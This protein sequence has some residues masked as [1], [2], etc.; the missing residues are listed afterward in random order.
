[1]GMEGRLDEIVVLMLDIGQGN[2]KLLDVLTP[3]C[4]RS[5]YGADSFTLENEYGK[6]LV[7]FRARQSV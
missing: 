1:M 7:P 6:F 3:E 2:E 4:I 5:V